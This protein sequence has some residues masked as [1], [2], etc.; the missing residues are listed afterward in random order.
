MRSIVFWRY[1]GHTI[2]I[3]VS[4]R[5][6]WVDMSMIKLNVQTAVLIPPRHS[7]GKPIFTRLIKSSRVVCQSCIRH[8]Y[9]LII[10]M[11]N[12]LLRVQ[13]SLRE[14]SFKPAPDV[15]KMSCLINLINLIKD[16]MS[17]IYAITISTRMPSRFEIMLTLTKIHHLRKIKILS[18]KDSAKTSKQ[19]AAI[20]NFVTDWFLS[21]T[22]KEIFEWHYQ[23]ISSR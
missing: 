2:I 4:F 22:K 10:A 7:D 9:P 6:E 8:K 5:F 23:S 19:N 15:K 11:T 16:E 14:L 12:Q 1:F 3:R 17:T 20:E 21:W 18:S 13:S